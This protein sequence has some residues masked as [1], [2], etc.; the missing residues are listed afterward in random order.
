MKILTEKKK[1]YLLLHAK[2]H[3]RQICVTF[4]SYINQSLNEIVK[5]SSNTAFYI[6]SIAPN[7]WDK[8]PFSREICD[9]ET[10]RKEDSQVKQKNSGSNHKF[11]DPSQLSSNSNTLTIFSYHYIKYY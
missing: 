4:S 1:D 3:N 9:T 5:L 2:E 6:L 11:S 7:C 10:E 8:I